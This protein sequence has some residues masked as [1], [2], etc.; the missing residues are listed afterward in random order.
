MISVPDTGQYSAVLNTDQGMQF[1]SRGF[2]E[3]LEPRGCGSPWTAGRLMDNMFIERLWRSLKY[4]E[5]FIKAYGSVAEARRAST[6]GSHSTT[7]NGHTRLWTI[8]RR[9][10]FSMTRSLCSCG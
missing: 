8:G 9:A 1:T 4:E 5:V 2:T 10:R 3:E 7:T 6:D